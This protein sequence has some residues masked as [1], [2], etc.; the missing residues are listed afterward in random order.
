MNIS[1]PIN[2]NNITHNN[3]HTTHDKHTHN[4]TTTHT[5]NNTFEDTSLVYN[6]L[7]KQAIHGLPNKSKRLI[8]INKLLHAKQY[9]VESKQPS[10]SVTNAPILQSSNDS[11]G[12][13]S[14]MTQEHSIIHNK[15]AKT[16]ISLKAK[17]N[18]MNLVVEKATS[19]YA[20]GTATSGFKTKI[21]DYRISL[22]Q[23]PHNG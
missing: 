18:L 7:E 10:K 13:C 11:I 9:T 22:I 14:L 12:S 6:I 20:S 5:T 4:T 21:T 23:G 8:A 19:M 1:L 3:T 17:A 15:Q 16:P 2:N